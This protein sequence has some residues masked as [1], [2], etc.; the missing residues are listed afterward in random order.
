VRQLP[1]DEL[2]DAL[3]MAPEAER[4]LIGAALVDPRVID[5]IDLGPGDF[6]D[7][8]N[9]K[10]WEAMKAGAHDLPLL[11]QRLGEDW[12]GGYIGELA[13]A[14]GYVT[15]VA[16]YA[17]E[18][19][20]A[21]GK[22]RLRELCIQGLQSCANGRSATG[23]ADWMKSE[24]ERHEEGTTR[25]DFAP[26]TCQQLMRADVSLDYLIEGLLVD[27][28]AMLVCGPYKSLKTSFLLDLA[29]ALT[30][31]GCFLGMFRVLRAV[32][33]AIV[34]GESGLATIKET[35]DRIARAALIDPEALTNLIISDRIPQLSNTAHLAALRQFI[36]ERAIEVLMIDPAY[37]AMADAGGDAGNLFLFGEQ[38]RRISALCQELGVLLILCH[39]TKKGAGADYEP[40]ELSS[41]AW[42]GFAEHCRQWLLLN[43]REKY[44]ESGTHRMHLRAGGSAG[45]GG[46]WAVDVHQGRQSDLGGRVWEVSVM[47][48]DEARQDVQA[49][50]TES[51]QRR[52]RE[53]LDTDRGEVVK[54]AVKGPDTKSGLRDGVS[55]GHK[56]FDAAFASLVQDG[57]LV[58]ADVTKPNGQSYPGWMLSNEQV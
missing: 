32:T 17:A 18:I 37:L 5:A 8:R 54:V 29:V 35:I 51:K 10:I 1:L 38:L 4:A 45:H 2:I 58:K 16:A 46:L 44:D 53:N 9:A 7:H 34:T 27:R 42:A 24:L 6:H 56:R 22:R 50:Q 52:Q 55:C 36:L 33:V 21:A 43:H 11:R 3:P 47:A 39:H 13:A 15:H 40:L 14:G 20:N 30:T 41:V 12:S 26:M 48:A 57:T 19:K 49:R 28:Q 23:I 25:F 31:A